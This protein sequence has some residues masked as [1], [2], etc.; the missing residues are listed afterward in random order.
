MRRIIFT[1]KSSAPLRRLAKPTMKKR[2]SSR[3]EAADAH[4]A[5]P[6]AHTGTPAGGFVYRKNPSS[7][8]YLI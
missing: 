5:R 3:L 4:N 1:P 8:H 2:A 6:R 7:Y